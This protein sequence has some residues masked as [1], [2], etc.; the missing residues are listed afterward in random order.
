MG[1]EN[2]FEHHSTRAKLSVANLLNS[3]PVI[4]L[5][6]PVLYGTLG[7]LKTIGQLSQQFCKFIRLKNNAQKT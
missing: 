5:L 4:F 6:K 7:G 3:G 2:D 1:F